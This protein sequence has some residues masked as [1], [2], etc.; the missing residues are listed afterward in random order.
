MKRAI[1]LVVALIVLVGCSSG[2]SDSGAMI[3]PDASYGDTNAKVGVASSE[4]AVAVDQQLIQSASITLRV[5]DV[6]AT[7]D[8]VSNYV[9]SIGGRIDS[10]NEYRDPES[11]EITSSDLTIR[12]PSAQLEVALEQLKTFGD[13]EGFSSSAYDVTLQVV[14]LDARIK[15]LESSIANLQNLLDQSTTVADLLAAEAAISQRQAE[16]DSLKSQRTYLA[17]QVELSAIWVNILPKRAL[18]AVR[19]IGFIAG[20]EKGWDAIVDFAGNLS[21]WAGLALPWIGLI[22][23]IGVFFRLLAAVL[24][25]RSS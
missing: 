1:A 7:T 25:R 20:I 21:T 13:L 15:S 8:E 18:D 2:S 10:K 16:L 5:D 12:V 3:S 23:V 9:S 19:P 17:D 6:A 14:D 24:R 11:S 4:S 22:V